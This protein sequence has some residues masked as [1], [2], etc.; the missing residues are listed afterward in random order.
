MK[1]MWKAA[2]CTI[3]ALGTLAAAGCGSEKKPAAGQTGT[4]T[5]Q[6][7]VQ[8]IQA[9]G[10]LVVGTSSGYPPYEFVDTSKSGTPVV[11]VDMALAQKIADQLGV[12][13]KVQDM[14]F[15][16]LLGAVSE[17]KVD[18]AIAGINASNERKRELIFSKPYMH[19]GQTL[20][21]R[22]DAAESFH[23]LDDFHGKTIGAQK[24]TLQEALVHDEVPDAE[25]KVFDKV[26]DMLEALKSGQVDAAA[27]EEIGAQ[28][29]LGVEPDLVD[30]GVHFE[31]VKSSSSVAAAKGNEKLLNVVNDVI[32]DNAGN[33]DGWIREYSELAVSIAKK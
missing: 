17:K 19:S 12:K 7:V 28:P 25:V 11:G 6:G 8:Q 5:P 30:S 14:E 13:L 20:L 32:D 21:V 18:L 22:K 15:S 2:I 29:Y 33:I 3:L 4:K 1:T 10:T 27:S 9:R 26:P 23:T 31:H 24:G 16:Q